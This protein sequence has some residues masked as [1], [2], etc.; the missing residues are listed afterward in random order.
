MCIEL[1]FQRNNFYF[2]RRRYAI[3]RHSL[4]LMELDRAVFFDEDVLKNQI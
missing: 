3:H 2:L 4:S 1:D